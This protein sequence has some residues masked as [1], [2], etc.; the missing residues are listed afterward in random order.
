MPNHM[1][2]PA[3]VIMNNDFYESLSP[4]YQQLITDACTEAREYATEYMNTAMEKDLQTCVDAGM[5]VCEPD[6][7]EF[8]AATQSVRDE[9]GVKT[10]GEDG[11][12][13]VKEIAANG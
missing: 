5:I 1:I 11:Y 3:F 4:E 2:K 10:W 9:L 13:I 7:A 6:L 8:K 12:A